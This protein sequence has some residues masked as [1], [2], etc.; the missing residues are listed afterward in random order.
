MTPPSLHRG[1]T[2]DG[3]W[4]QVSHRPECVVV[5]VGG[6][7]DLYSAARLADTLHA[8]I[9]AALGLVIDLT[10]LA[11]I[12][13]SGLGVLISA[14]NE[15]DLRRIP[16]VLVHPPRLLQRL[17]TSTQTQRDL[18]AFETLDDAVAALSKS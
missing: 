17:L 9:P 16:M 11:F 6:E 7:V 8:V 2:S 10:H 1:G 3:A 5:T 14:R 12:D 15:A 13:S 18:P 4:I